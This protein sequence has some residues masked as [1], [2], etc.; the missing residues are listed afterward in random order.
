MNAGSPPARTKTQ[1]Y[2]DS[3]AMIDAFFE[4]KDASEKKNREL[5]VARS[6][7]ASDQELDQIEEA[8]M[9]KIAK[10]NEKFS[11]E[12]EKYK[13]PVGQTRTRENIRGQTRSGRNARSTWF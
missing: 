4:F 8:W 2:E 13:N 11:I 5:E 1:Y 6:E 12:A 9:K 10:A 7:N 3:A